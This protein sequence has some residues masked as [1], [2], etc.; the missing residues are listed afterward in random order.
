[1][2]CSWLVNEVTQVAYLCVGCRVFHFIN[3]MSLLAAVHNSKRL[4]A[5]FGDFQAMET[6]C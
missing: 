3:C 4:N 6:N 2:A 5:D 1:M